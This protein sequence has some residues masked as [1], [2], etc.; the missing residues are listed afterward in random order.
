MALAGHLEAGGFDQTA[1]ERVRPATLAGPG[2]RP[3]PGSGRR[4]ARSGQATN[5]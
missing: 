1:P 3:S 2:R 4:T 5:G